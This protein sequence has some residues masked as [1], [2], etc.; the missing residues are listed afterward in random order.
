M[1]L[2]YPYFWEIVSINIDQGLVT[3][4]ITPENNIL[5]PI[6]FSMPYINYEEQII[7]GVVSYI[8]VPFTTLVEDMALGY[9]RQWKNQEYILNESVALLNLC[10]RVE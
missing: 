2:E 6:K 4:Q 9:Q 7:D 10:G 5:S 1:T 3:V 8:E